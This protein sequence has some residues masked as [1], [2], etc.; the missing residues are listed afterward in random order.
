MGTVTLVAIA[1][2]PVMELMVAV[3]AG[4]A[5]GQVQ[6]AATGDPGESWEDVTAEDMADVD[7]TE[8]AATS[9]VAV[10]A[11]AA[12]AVREVSLGRAVAQQEGLLA[13]AGSVR[14]RTWESRIPNNSC[15][16]LGTESR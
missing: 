4:M 3:A 12:A 11:W 15:C 9:V 1:E 10:M 6:A 5:A 2:I 13:V 7:S 8:V 16:S 14:V